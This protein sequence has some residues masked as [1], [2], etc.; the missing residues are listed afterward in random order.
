VGLAPDGS[1]LPLSYN[2][3]DTHPITLQSYL[4]EPFRGAQQSTPQERDAIRKHAAARMRIGI[5]M[6]CAVEAVQDSIAFRWKRSMR[7]AALVLSGIGGDCCERACSAGVDPLSRRH[8]DHWGA[9]GI[10]SSSGARS[11]S[12]GGKLERLMT[13]CRVRSWRKR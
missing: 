8:A 9:C 12:R 1:S 7:I 4:N 13:M 2:F 6:R 5:E 3:D 10:S 11:G